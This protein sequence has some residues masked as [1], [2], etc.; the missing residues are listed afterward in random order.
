MENSTVDLA[1]P[2]VGVLS[3][4]PNNSYAA[5]TGTSQTA[6]HVAGVAALVKSK[7]TRALPTR[8]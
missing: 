2:G 6:P 5:Y 3:T 1:A 4:V 8:G 7:N